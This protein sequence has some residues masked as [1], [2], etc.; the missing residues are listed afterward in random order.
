MSYD[1][2]SSQSSN[3]LDPDGSGITWTPDGL[4]WPGLEAVSSTSSVTGLTSSVSPYLLTMRY[5][6]TRAMNATKFC[7]SLQVSEGNYYLVRAVFWSGGG[8]T[9]PYKTLRNGI[10]R[11]SVIVDTYVVQEIVITLP[12]SDA[13]IEEMYVRAQSSLLKVCLS[14]ASATSDV[15]FINSLELRSL[16]G[17][18][19]LTL[20]SLVKVTG[21]PVRLVNRQDFGV[22][23]SSTNPLIPR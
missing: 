7:Y 3:Y 9:L 17:S 5:F 23:P 12:Q 14:A 18:D 2:G 15:P 16:G 11:F 6:P 8:V 10:V 20:V 19:A 22:S 21:K 13:W 1:C 4:K